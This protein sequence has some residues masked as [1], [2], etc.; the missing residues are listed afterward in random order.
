M[1]TKARLTT[2]GD[3]SPS[4]E[5]A[6]HDLQMLAMGMSADELQRFCEGTMN[7]LVVME[8]QFRKRFPDE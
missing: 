4:S 6:L 5:R 2:T 1:T 8:D 7:A 3:A